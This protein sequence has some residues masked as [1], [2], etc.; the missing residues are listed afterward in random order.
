MNF[1]STRGQCPPADLRTAILDGLA[2]DG[3]LY[4]PER[5]PR[6]SERFFA[7]LPGSPLADTAAAVASG[8]PVLGMKFTGDKLSPPERFETLRRTFGENFIGIEIDSSDGNAHG[9][10]ADAHSVVTEHFVDEPGHPTREAW[11]TMVDFFR[12][13]LE[14][15]AG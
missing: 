12:T 3:G 11:D 7:G 9:I 4:V 5:I 10:P 14:V 8:C 6:L 15:P 1:V 13:R 2:P